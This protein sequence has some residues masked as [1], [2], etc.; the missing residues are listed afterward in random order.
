M[1]Y[2]IKVSIEAE[3]EIKKAKVWYENKQSG[4]GE[5]FSI[6]IKEHINKLKL[7][8][9]EHKIVFKN[10]RRVLTSQFPFV[11]Y[12]TRDELKLE[13]KILAVLH[14]RRQQYKE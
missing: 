12:Y 4:L 9:V 8:S 3:A 2:K 11:I 1:N 14:E 13:V 7:S 5:R 10:V 6:V